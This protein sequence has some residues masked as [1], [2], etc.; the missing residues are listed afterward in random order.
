LTALRQVFS[1]TEDPTFGDRALSI[2]RDDCVLSPHIYHTDAQL[3]E[4]VFN[5]ASYT[6]Q[7]NGLPVAVPLY[8]QALYL[9]SGSYMADV[10]SSDTW[11]QERHDLL[12]NM[13]VI[14]AERLA[15]HAYGQRRYR[16][17]IALCRQALCVDPAADD[18]TAWLLRACAR[19]GLYDELERAYRGYLH[20]AMVEPESAE[21]QQDI[22]AQTY[23]GLNRARAVGE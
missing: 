5:I 18:V 16:Q 10:P 1:H 20:A 4:R 9:Y 15:E 17:C 14:T 8:S 12:M 23:Q 7:A 22:V 6:E 19:V 21:L 13:F 2:T 3:F 11:S